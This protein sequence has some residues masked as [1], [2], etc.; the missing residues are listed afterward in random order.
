[1]MKY[2][3]R[4]S[5]YYNAYEKSYKSKSGDDIVIFGYYSD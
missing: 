3:E 2:L 1:M 5:I 4:F